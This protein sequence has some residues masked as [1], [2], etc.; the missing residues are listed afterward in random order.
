M[1]FARIIN[2]MLNRFRCALDCDWDLTRVRAALGA[3]VFSAICYSVTVA[4]RIVEWSPIRRRVAVRIAGTN[5]ASS[6]ERKC[7]VSEADD[8]LAN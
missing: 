8:E 5:R 1:R 6:P 3:H 2:P 4:A 7:D